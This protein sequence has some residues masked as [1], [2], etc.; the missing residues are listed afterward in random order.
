MDADD[1]D[2]ND[3][4]DDADDDDDDGGDDDDD[5]A[6]DDDD[7]DGVVVVVDDDDDDDDDAGDDDDDADDDV[8][9]GDDDDD[10]DD[11]HGDDACLPC[12]PST[13]ALVENCDELEP[14]GGRCALLFNVFFFFLHFLKVMRE[15][16]AFLLGV[17]PRAADVANDAGQLQI[18]RVLLQ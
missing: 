5:D 18:H 2:D 4:D 7:D 17:A 6:D 12:F 1:D 8:D 13:K 15:K 3:D 9:D 16:M 10:D 11:D 14:R